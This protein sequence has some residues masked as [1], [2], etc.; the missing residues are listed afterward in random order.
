M[1]AT[2]GSSPPIRITV[3]IS[4]GGSNLQV[5]ID[6]CNTEALPN[7]NIIRVISDR[8]NAYGLERA[9]AAKIPTTHLGILK[10]KEKYPDSSAEPRFDD[11][12]K[13]YD[14]DL[15]KIVLDDEPDI[16][17]CAGFMRILTTSFLNPI[18]GAKTPTI[19]L[20]PSAPGDLVGAGC[21][22][23]A[24]EEFE[25]GKRTR[26]GIMIHYVIEEVDMGEPIVSENIEI[27]GCKV[28][29]DLETRIHEREHAL[30]VKGAK[31]AIKKL[32][33]EGKA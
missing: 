11:A 21:I 29:G 2:I 17:V 25:A 27:T 26:T 4:G 18:K 3:L 28:L 33:S 23:R 32:R 12:R 9:K 14:T 19:N 31:G 13:A 15:A 5:L 6:A 10:Y 16:V 1:A 30:I 22:K 8:K 7:A 24:W 20:H